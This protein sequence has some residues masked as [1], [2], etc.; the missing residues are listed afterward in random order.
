MMDRYEH[1]HFNYFIFLH[2]YHTNPYLFDVDSHI[3]ICGS[4]GQRD[5]RAR[6]VLFD[7]LPDSVQRGGE[8]G[9]VEGC[10]LSVRR[11]DALLLVTT[12]SD[13]H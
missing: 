5:R 1:F 2:F 4:T 3:I 7:R 6:Q 12:A 10:G 8:P 9:G 11:R 13:I